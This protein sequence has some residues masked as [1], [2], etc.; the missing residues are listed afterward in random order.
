V[1]LVVRGGL[2]DYVF[3]AGDEE[4]FGGAEAG[5]R[6]TGGVGDLGCIFAGLFEEAAWPRI[7]KKRVSA[8]YL[9]PS[10]G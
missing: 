2:F 10:T 3:D 4:V 6:G 1:R 7:F 5:E 9:Y 8:H